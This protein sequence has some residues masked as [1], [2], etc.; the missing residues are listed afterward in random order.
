MTHLYSTS[1]FPLS[2]SLCSLYLCV[3]ISSCF[4]LFGC[5]P[6]P[7]LGPDLGTQKNLFLTALDFDTEIITR[8][9]CLK[10]LVHL[11]AVRDF[12]VADFE[13]TVIGFDAG[14]LSPS[15]WHDPLDDHTFLP[16]LDPHA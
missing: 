9:I 11:L 3:S 14:F 15:A 4:N 8:L 1:T 13:D 6:L 5:F 7:A 16:L 12:A 2:S 10:S